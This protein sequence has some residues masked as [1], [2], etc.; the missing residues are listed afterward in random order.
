MGLAE[1]VVP[2]LGTRQACRERDVLEVP[3]TFLTKICMVS[4]S[5]AWEL[6]LEMLLERRIMARCV[7]GEVEMAGGAWRWES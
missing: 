1:S 4:S 5:E 7:G 3:E 2:S 6:M